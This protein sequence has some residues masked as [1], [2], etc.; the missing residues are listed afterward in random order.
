MAKIL[1]RGTTDYAQQGNHIKSAPSRSPQP[2]PEQEEEGPGGYIVRNL[3]KIP[4]L[5]YELARSGLGAGN[6]AN[7]A[8]RETGLFNQKQTPNQYK[9]GTPEHYLEFKKSSP[10]NRP[11]EL[12]RTI[13]PTTQQA[14]KEAEAAFSTVSSNPKYFTEHRP[15]DYWAET[16]LTSIPFLARGAAHGATGL[17]R[18]ALQQAG[19]L[20][21]S[22]IGRLAGGAL[23]ETI[24][25]EELGSALGG[26]GGGILGHK[27]VNALSNRPSKIIEP[28]VEEKKQA[29]INRPLEEI[30]TAKESMLNE[31]LA[32]IHRE[33]KA[34]KES[35]A[36]KPLMEIES[37]G[38][39]L[40]QLEVE[41]APLYKK[42]EQLEGKSTGSPSS[43]QPV[44]DQVNERLELGIDPADYTKINKILAPLEGA[45]KKRSLSLNKTKKF[46]KN[47][48]E[49]IYDRS[50]SNSFKNILHPVVEGLNNFI[51]KIGTPE[52]T[53]AWKQ[54][55]G[56]HK[57]FAQLKKGRKDFIASKKLE[58]AK[59][60]A[61]YQRFLDEKKFEESKVRQNYKDFVAEKN[62]EHKKLQDDYHSSTNKFDQLVKDFS[63]SKYGGNRASLIGLGG[64]GYTLKHIFGFAPAAAITGAVKGVNLI[65]SEM[66][67]A[68][69][70]LK[71]HPEIYAEYAKLA[72]ELPRIDKARL[73]S[74]LADLGQKTQDII[75]EENV[76][77][78]KQSSR[79]KIIKR[80]NK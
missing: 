52:H 28:K 26:L 59:N 19:L 14:N 11:E 62:I 33:I 70:A 30:K 15:E 35:V 31:P 47:Y 78:Q 32:K 51:E 39:K 60:K 64:L 3:A 77:P 67:I 55:E 9:P 75:D 44:I 58:L 1:R 18:A 37:Y 50:A 49:Q 5:G 4:T 10:L 20:G 25:K 17:G 74:T 71:N 66:K 56:T 16:A 57:E 38:K 24:G 43:L 36:N 61:D 22:E 68:A 73:V 69:D 27:A 7:L 23:G 54:A 80:G 45:I 46:Q 13:L 29:I 34:K 72:A 41:R 76:S 40:K 12:L 53:Q 6:L 2:Q 79:V 65:R 63:K 21:G 48:N 42:A 8:A